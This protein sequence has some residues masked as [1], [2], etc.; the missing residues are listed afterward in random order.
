MKIIYNKILP[1]G[2]QYHAINLFGVLFA[3][4]PCGQF[5]VNHEKIHT[6]QIKELGY[7]FFYILYLPEWLWKLLL[8]R[9]S[10]KAYENISFEREA[11]RND[12][13]LS[14]LHTR[15]HYSWI[16]HLRRQSD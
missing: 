7:I 15:R 2:R 3:K 4:G 10:Y 12:H 14:Y 11:Y 1:F 16:K 9:D 5:T 6:S 13:N 8:Y